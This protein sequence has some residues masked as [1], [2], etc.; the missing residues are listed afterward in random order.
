MFLVQVLRI[1][2]LVAS[3]EENSTFCCTLTKK[4][5]VTVLVIGIVSVWLSV[6][7]LKYCGWDVGRQEV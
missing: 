4:Q 7:E 2:R 6:E 5:H 3:T 1:Q